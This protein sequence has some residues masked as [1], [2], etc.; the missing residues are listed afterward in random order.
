MSSSI[1]VQQPAPRPRQQAVHDHECR[2]VEAAKAGGAVKDTDGALV[3]QSGRGIVRLTGRANDRRK[4]VLSDVNFSLTSDRSLS[5]GGIRTKLQ[6]QG[7]KR[8]LAMFNLAIDSKLRGCGV[9]ALKVE[10]VAPDGVS[11]IAP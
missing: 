7:R 4:P 11:L 9:V 3:E 2:L 6:L 10:D 1:R 5:G 8:D